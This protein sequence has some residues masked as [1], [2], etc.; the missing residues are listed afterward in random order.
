MYD[1]WYAR[2]VAAMQS[3]AEEVRSGLFPTAAHSFGMSVAPAAVTTSSAAVDA[4]NPALE[5]KP[6]DTH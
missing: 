4:A 3:Y 6:V 2:G 5:A 1:N